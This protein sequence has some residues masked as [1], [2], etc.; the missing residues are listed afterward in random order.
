VISRQNFFVF[1]PLLAEIAGGSIN[2][3]DGVTPLRRFL[4]GVAVMVAEVREINLGAKTVAV[5]LGRDRGITA[6]P[7]DQLVLALGQVV[8]LSRTPGLADR[9][10]VMKDVM[11]AFHIRNQ[12]LG[13]L[14]DADAT[15]GAGNRSSPSSPSAEGSPASRRSARFRN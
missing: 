1:Q 12:V 4:P 6:V 15:R 7:Y 5:A 2:A 14:E 9:A 8:D 10:F 11:D 3:A 13:C